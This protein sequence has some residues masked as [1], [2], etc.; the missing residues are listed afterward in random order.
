M[1]LNRL[2]ED[3]LVMQELQK[4]Q[5]D[6]CGFTKLAA[7]ITDCFGN[8]LTHLSNFSD[9]CNMMR[10]QGNFC[11]DSD[12]KGGKLAAKMDDVCIYICHAKLVDLAVP[13]IVDGEHIGTIM[14]GQVRTDKKLTVDFSV[15][16]C[17]SFW[18]ENETMYK[19]Y[20]EI[21]FIDHEHLEKAAKILNIIA[22]Y[23]CEKVKAYRMKQLLTDDEDKDVYISNFRKD[24]SSIVEDIRKVNY[25]TA[26]KQLLLL[27]KRYFSHKK[28]ITDHEVLKNI[29]HDELKNLGIDFL[30][31]KEIYAYK[32][33]SFIG[34]SVQ[35]EYFYKLFDMIF[36]KIILQKRFRKYDEFDWVIEYIHRFYY[37]KISV[38]DMADYINL[39]PDY[40]SKRFKK[41]MHMTFI[42]YVTIVK[43]NEAKKL[44]NFSSLPIVSIAIELGYPEPNYFTRVFK[45]HVGMTPTEYR[46]KNNGIR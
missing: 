27:I 13:I 23:I 39:S 15:A 20:N 42:E 41:K 10:E 18:R 26:K 16:E 34:E 35:G 28:H 24:L 2:M 3:A 43:I 6:F 7:V 5:D 12:R 9:F 38:Q 36:E 21:P 1:E 17:S 19:A 29:L 4:M 37:R 32:D 22:N 31:E 11:C 46:Q 25:K 45:K 30:T 40:F 8:K 33:S 14:C 44:L